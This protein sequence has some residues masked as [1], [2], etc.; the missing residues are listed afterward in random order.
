MKTQTWRKAYENAE[1][2][3]NFDLIITRFGLTK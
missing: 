3:V 1:I 2:D